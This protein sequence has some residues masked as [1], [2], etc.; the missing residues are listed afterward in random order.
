M[1]TPHQ[2]WLTGDQPIESAEQDRLNRKEF[3]RELATAISTWTGRQSLTVAVN[4]SWGSGKTSIKNLA[5]QTLTSQAD[6]D[7]AVIEFNPWR[8]VSQ[9]QLADAF[10]R[11][12]GQALGHRIR[13]DESKEI[14]KRWRKYAAL[15]D[16]G[17]QV[18]SGFQQAL[19]WA[20]GGSGALSL[21]AAIIP[22]PSTVRSVIAGLGALAVI[23]A[24]LLLKSG[25]V[26]GK[27]ADY[28]DAR[29][30]DAA[31]TLEQAKHDLAKVL[32]KRKAPIVVILDDVDRLTEAQTALMFQLVKANA[33]LPNFV[34]LMLFQRDVVERSLNS[35]A[36][37][38]GADF[39]EKIVQIVLDIPKIEHSRVEAVLFEGLNAFLKGVSEG[40]FDQVRWGNVYVGGLRQYFETLRDVKRYLASLSFYLTL[41]KGEAGIEVDA[42]D[43]LAIEAIRVFV[44]GVYAALAN[45][46]DI[47]TG[48][49]RPSNRNAQEAF[50]GR[51]N[52]VLA[53]EPDERREALKSVLIELFPG[54][55]WVFGGMERSAGHLATWLKERRICSPELFDR[56]FQFTISE[57]DIS[58]AELQQVIA[59]AGDRQQLLVALQAINRRGLMGLL[60]ERLE[61]HK[62]EIPLEAAVPLV[63]ALFDMGDELPEDPP[64][65]FVGPSNLIRR[66][67]HWYLKREPDEAQR[68]EILSRALHETTGLYQPLMLT[69]DENNEKRREEKP[70]AFLVSADHAA[71][72]KSE[73]VEKIRAAAR[74]T[75]LVTSDRLGSILYRWLDWGSPEEVRGWVSN[76][77]SSPEGALIILRGLVQRGTTQSIGDKVARLTWR[78][79]L[80]ELEKFV[81]L[82]KFQ[83]QIEKLGR[84]NLNERD[85]NSLRAFERAIRHR[86]QGKP[87]NSWFDDDDDNRN[88]LQKSGVETVEQRP[89]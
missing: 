77:A 25:K 64:G 36:S 21:V 26:A 22:V 29:A 28:F 83:V 60:A 58:Q 71:A 63:T 17:S 10:F 57:N 68:F 87:D 88:Q 44:P 66:L 16:V 14:A 73:Y 84:S 61:A 7:V 8:W 3:A 81:D 43:L 13:G 48:V 20:L 37:G 4:G 27:A 76:I 35:I 78:A 56:F 75:K 11:E 67:T 41:L 40:E 62:D 80:T 39:L 45:A 18:T 69:M 42:I 24:T 30:S 12:V 9:D 70:E 15:L 50:K 46:K 53:L 34:Y 1:T 85:R 23:A 5:V 52:S 65:T 74:D 32:A 55:G 38:A 89:R 33:D 49:G 47:L 72:L 31:Q 6:S 54:I 79:S 19:T 82:P 59:L 2:S 86:S 51:V